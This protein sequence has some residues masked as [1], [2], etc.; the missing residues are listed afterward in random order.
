LAH[1]ATGDVD[2]HGMKRRKFAQLATK[3]LNAAAHG[4]GFDELVL[5]VPTR[6]RQG[7][8]RD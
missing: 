6:A 4:D 2:P 8:P 5:V 1:H 7:L 3:Q